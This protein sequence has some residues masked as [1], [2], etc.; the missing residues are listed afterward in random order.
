MPS[1]SRTR[2]EVVGQPLPRQV[3]EDRGEGDDRWLVVG[4]QRPGF[5]VRWDREEPTRS[6]GSISDASSSVSRSWPV[7]IDAMWRTFIRRGMA[8]APARCREVLAH[9]VVERQP[10]AELQAERGA[11]ERLAQRVHEAD[12]I[13]RGG[14]Q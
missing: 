6:S 2:A 7:A 10:L 1:G 11:G 8:T 5:G 13:G 9:Q 4:E 12:A 14:A 3:L